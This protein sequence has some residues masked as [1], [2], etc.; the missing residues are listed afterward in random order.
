MAPMSR[1]ANNAIVKKAFTEGT[2]I[3]YHRFIARER[4]MYRGPNIPDHVIQGTF[5]IKMLK[6]LS[7]GGFEVHLQNTDDPTHIVMMSNVNDE[8]AELIEALKI[9]P[10][11]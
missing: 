6:G 1:A 11:S 5:R 10:E 7:K 2:E 9:D 3:P 8:L 4:K